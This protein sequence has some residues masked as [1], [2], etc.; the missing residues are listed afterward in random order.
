VDLRRHSQRVSCASTA[1]AVI[2]PTRMQAAMA[3]RLRLYI[4]STI[5]KQE[6]E[7][8]AEEEEAEE[9]EICC[10]TP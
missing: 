5:Q 8:E 3:I 10:F 7:K 2:I 1:A 6:A 9:A 4:A